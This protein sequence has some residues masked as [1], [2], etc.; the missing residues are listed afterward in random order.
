[1]QCDIDSAIAYESEVF[2][3]CFATEDQTEGMSA[4]LEK[5]DKCFKNK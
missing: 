5:R 2:G 4:F 3:E 1:M